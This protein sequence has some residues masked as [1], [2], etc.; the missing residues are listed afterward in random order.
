MH[1]KI[2][3]LLWLAALLLLAACAPAAEQTAD[4]PAATG[5]AQRMGGP[6]SGMMARHQAPIPDEYAGLENPIPADDASLARGAEHYTTYCVACHGEGG[7]GD[8]PAGQ[9]LDPP[10]A[11]IAHTSRMLGDDYLFWR[12]SEGGLHE[13]FLSAM[14]RWQDLLDEDARWDVINYVRALGSGTVQ[15]GRGPGAAFD[16]AAE[17]ARHA[18]IAAEGVAAGVLTQEEANAFVAVHALLD[19]LAGRGT[20]AGNM[21]QRQAAL[22]AELVADGRITQAEADLFDRAH[23]ALLEAGLMP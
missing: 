9:S 23:A 17:A 3:L 2:W 18:E 4:S 15:P 8:G 11:P 10:A 12:I 19:P 6:G 1:K 5:V 14:P 20:G 16:A 13:P 7:M 22:L 21:D